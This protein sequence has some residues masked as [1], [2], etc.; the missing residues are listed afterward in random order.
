MGRTFKY[1]GDNH[2]ATHTAERH[3]FIF[4]IDLDDLQRLNKT[5]VVAKN[6]SDV[7]YEPIDVTFKGRFDRDLVGTLNS[8]TVTS[9][10][11]D[12][13]GSSSTLT[14]LDIQSSRYFYPTDD[15]LAGKLI[16][17]SNRVVGSQ[18]SDTIEEGAGDD[19]LIGGDGSD[20]LNGGAGNDLIRGGRF[21][22]YITGGEGIDKIYGGRGRDRF[23][24][25]TGDGFDRIMDFGRSYDKAIINDTD[26]A[27]VSLQSAGKKGNSTKV[28][29]G[30]DHVATLKGV[31]MD[32]LNV[33]TDDFGYDVTITELI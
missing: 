19:T 32:T 12:A 7:W 9:V 1:T 28:Y 31:Q 10:A 3:N 29:V 15:S 26:L 17:K 22:D 30:D 6:I 25:T 24:L 13:N 23:Y 33:T 14:G 18:S 4:D 27:D 16:A 2:R 21:T 8:I 5:T 20:T 11:A